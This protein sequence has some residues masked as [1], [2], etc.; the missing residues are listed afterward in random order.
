MK[1]RKRSLP[2]RERGLKSSIGT[3][4]AMIADSSLPSRERGL[5]LFSGKNK[6]F[7]PNVAPFAGAWIEI[8]IA[9]SDAPYVYCR[10]L[11]GSVD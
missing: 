11:R 6:K 1:R 10:S 5:K 8:K 7:E 2:S 9:E 4:F 3:S